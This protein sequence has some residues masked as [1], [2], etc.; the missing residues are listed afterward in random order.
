MPTIKTKKEMNE[1]E[2]IK[3][4]VDRESTN[5][6]SSGISIDG[7]WISIEPE[8]ERK[9]DFQLKEVFTDGKIYTVEIEVPIT[10]DTVIP[11]IIGILRSKYSNSKVSMMH[12]DKSVNEIIKGNNSN[13]LHYET[14][15]LHVINDDDTHTL[16]WHDGKLVE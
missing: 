2:L 1:K 13:G 5:I 11:Q 9:V 3:Y 16:I 12:N 14:L 6:Y 15:T 10:E 4:L 7:A 8:I